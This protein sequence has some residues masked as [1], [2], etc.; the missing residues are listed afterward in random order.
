MK[1]EVI[2][3]HEILEKFIKDKDKFDLIVSNKRASFNKNGLDYKPNISFQKICHD[4][5]KSN[6][7]I[8]KCKF[9]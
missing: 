5:K 7:L 4:R 1:N 6:H 9:C 3:L 2:N 8:F